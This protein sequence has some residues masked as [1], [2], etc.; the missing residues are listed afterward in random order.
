MV[1]VLYCLITNSAFAFLCIIYQ[2]PLGDL[3]SYI[4]AASALQMSQVVEQCLHTVSQYLS[5]TL[6]FLKL[7]RRSGGKEIQQPDSSREIRNSNNLEE[8]NAAQQSSSIQEAST[9]E[10][11]ADVVRPK[12]TVSQVAKGSNDSQRKVREYDAEIKI[13]EDTACCPENQVH[14]I[15]G[16]ETTKLSPPT[17]FTDP[18]SYTSVRYPHIETVDCSQD[19]KELEE[20]KEEEEKFSLE[21]QLQNSGELMDSNLLCLSGVHFSESHFTVDRPAEDTDSIFVQRPYL[22]RRCDTVFQHL[23]SYVGHLKQHRQYL[24]LICE[25]LFSQRNNLTRHIRVRAGIK[26]FR[27]PLC[28]KTFSQRA[29]LQDHLIVHTGYK[30]HK[31]KSCA[32][33]S[34]HKAPPGGRPR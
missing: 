13:S 22:C 30:P 9:V 29:A 24:C 23:E 17:S 15:A 3:V 31:C 10:G 14:P 8:M 16:D 2:V 21:A 32:V 33:S 19:E 26:D 4:T 5:P 20:P 34:S 18:I 12:T 1:H 7:E 27:C 6:A 28:H 25:K 11:K